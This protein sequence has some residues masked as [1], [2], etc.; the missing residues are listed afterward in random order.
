MPQRS[1]RFAV[2]TAALA[3]A[4]LAGL[5]G[6]ASADMTVTGDQAA[7]QE[8]QAAFAKLN[9]LP[10][11]RMKSTMA[12]GGT[13]V[14]EVTSGGNM[15]HMLMHTP[16]GNMESYTV[17]GQTRMKNDMPGA[18]PGWHC[19]GPQAPMAG[20]PDPTKAQGTVDIA[21]GQDA[22]ID[23]QPAH[24]YVYTVQ[25]GGQSSKQTLYVGAANGLPRRVVIAAPG[26]DQTMDYYDYGAAIQFTA[27][28][29]M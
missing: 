6:A 3:L 29:C 1:A 17:N 19:I 11:Y 28:A 25:S 27:P 12:G 14:I 16:S 22:T 18:L 15:M 24:T 13:I 26:G 20:Q 10:G 5:A 2:T 21:R 7:W 4:V 23:G 9:T 8:V